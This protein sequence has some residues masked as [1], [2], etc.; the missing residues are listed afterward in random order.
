MGFLY[1]VYIN[2][3]EISTSPP[4]TVHCNVPQQNSACKYYADMLTQRT[5]A[6]QTDSLKPVVQTV[7]DFLK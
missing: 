6:P 2:I 7:R 4:S 3:P 5:A 1:S